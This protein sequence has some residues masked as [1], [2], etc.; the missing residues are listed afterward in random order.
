MRV[1]VMGDCLAYPVNQCTCFGGDAH[2]GHEPGCGYEPMATIGEVKAALIA[3][4]YT[5][6]DPT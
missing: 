5:I 2:Y 4:G 3:A 1:T 6:T